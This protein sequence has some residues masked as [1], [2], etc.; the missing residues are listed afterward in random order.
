M[1][2]RRRITRKKSRRMRGG[3][4]TMPYPDFDNYE[5]SEDKAEEYGER[6]GRYNRGDTY[7]TKEESEFPKPKNK[8]EEIYSKAYYAA[9]G[10]AKIDPN[11]VEPQGEVR[12]VLGFDEQQ[13]ERG[14][15]QRETTQAYRPDATSSSNQTSTS[16]SIKED[17]DEDPTNV[18]K[19]GRKRR[20]TRKHTKKS[21]KHRK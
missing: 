1:V 12:M 9:R 6:D 15:G 18:D 17:V 4:G 20:R 11:Y 2:K 13:R 21:R 14:M 16:S 8:I 19:G 10:P 3:F 5:T 7:R